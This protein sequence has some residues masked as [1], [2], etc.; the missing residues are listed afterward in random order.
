MRRAQ[1]LE[2]VELARRAA[3]RLEHPAGQASVR[4][5]EIVGLREVKPQLPLHALRERGE[6]PDASAVIAPYRRIVRTSVRA[7]GIIRTRSR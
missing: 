1:L 6:P 5:L 3:D 4:D 7:P 2:Q